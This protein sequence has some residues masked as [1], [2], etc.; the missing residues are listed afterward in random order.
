[1]L[2]KKKKEAAKSIGDLIQ[3][4]ERENVKFAHK[5]SIPTYSTGGGVIW[6]RVTV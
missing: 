1:M 4:E 3:G 2:K 5:R 6:I